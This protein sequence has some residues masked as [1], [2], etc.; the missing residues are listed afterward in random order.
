M[1]LMRILLLIALT[2]STSPATIESASTNRE[3]YS[4]GPNFNANA[5]SGPVAAIRKIPPSNP[6]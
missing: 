4:Q 1:T 5:A 3:K 6:P 2:L